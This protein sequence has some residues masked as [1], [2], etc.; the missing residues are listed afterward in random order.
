MESEIQP[1]Q[2]PLLETVIEIRFPGE[3]R[4]EV[5]RADYQDLIRADFPVLAVPLA[6][7]TQAPALQHYRF[8]NTAGTEFVGLAVNSFAHST[9]EY[10]GWV[11]FRDASR[12]YWEMI[13]K[14]TP[15]AI[16]R[17]GL[18]YINRFDGDMLEKIIIDNN[19]GLFGPIFVNPAL[20]RSTTVLAVG[21]NPLVVNIDWMLLEKRVTLD[22]DCFAE[23]VEVE[24]LWDVVE[25]LHE[26]IEAHF[27][28]LLTPEYRSQLQPTEGND[29]SA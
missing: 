10:P 8:V 16:S 17:V 25:S 14:F 2:V 13:P 29:G 19:N 11:S 7:P 27:F 12:K 5:C 22:F 23:N 20:H 28:S 6:N 3:A 4:I 24:D 15:K 1:V 9:K 18:R 21:E 26:G